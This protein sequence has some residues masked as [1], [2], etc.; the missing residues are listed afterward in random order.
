MTIDGQTWEKKSVF[1]DKGMPVDLWL[2]SPPMQN[3][4]LCHSCSPRIHS[5][6]NNNHLAWQKFSPSGINVGLRFYKMSSSIS[7]K[8]WG[9]LQAYLRATPIQHLLVHSG[10]IHCLL[11]NPEQQMLRRE[12]ATVPQS[13]SDAS[14]NCSRN[15]EYFKHAG[16]SLFWAIFLKSKKIPCFLGLNIV[17]IIL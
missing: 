7:E 11:H 15:I 5:R 2:R 4:L 13:L 9:N 12:L 17:I 16:D 14:D 3:S 8:S 10:S 1:V 6:I